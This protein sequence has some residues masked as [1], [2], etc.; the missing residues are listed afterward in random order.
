MGFYVQDVL[1]AQ[2]KTFVL[3]KKDWNIKNTTLGFMLHLMFCK[4][5]AA[6]WFFP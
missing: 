6:F 2:V 3:S 5:F 1:P 4:S